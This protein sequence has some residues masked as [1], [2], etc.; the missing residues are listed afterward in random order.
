MMGSNLKG[1]ENLQIHFVGNS[2]VGNLMAI[3]NGR[4]EVRTRIGNPHFIPEGN[5]VL[6]KDGGD[7]A[8]SKFLGEGQLQVTR[9]HPLWKQPQCG[10]V[11]ME[12]ELSIPLNLALYMAQSDQR[13]AVLLTD[14]V[15]EGGLCRT[16]L[17]LMVEALPGATDNNIEKAIANLEIIKAKGLRSYLAGDP[18]TFNWVA[19]DSESKDS[20]SNFRDFFQPLMAILDD[21]L[22]EVELDEEGAL[23]ELDQGISWSKF[24]KFKCTCG[25][26]RV[27]RT[28]TLLSKRDLKE[29]V[30]EGTPVEMKCDFCGENY[31]V[32][33]DE[34]KA[35][36]EAKLGGPV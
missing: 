6:L 14:V 24:P 30:E 35:K 12:N 22:K 20:S 2:G 17:G 25:I 36:F 15:V 21:T 1:D 5:M 18:S 26:D 13:K 33:N 4:L 10:I 29:I 11:S 8:C 28:L 34:V 16:A 19:S 23:L 27:W 31:S 32:P 3:T 7:E 9:S